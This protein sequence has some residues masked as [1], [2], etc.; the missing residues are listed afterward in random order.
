MS[1]HFVTIWILLVFPLLVIT[2]DIAADIAADL[3][4]VSVTIKSKS[5]EGSGVIIKRG[6][7][8]FVL[9]AG[10]VISDLRRLR[11]II[12]PR[13]GSTR[14]I[15]E[16]DEAKVIQNIY[17]NGRE[18][19][20]L[21]MLAVVICFSDAEYGE[22]IAL[23]RILKSNF[24]NASVS[25]YLDDM[26]PAVGTELYHVGSLHGHFGSNSVTTGIISQIGRIHKG[27]LYDQTNCTAFPGSSGGGVFIKENGECIGLLVRGSGGT[28]NLL[29]PIR[30]IQEWAKRMNVEFVLDPSVRVP[31]IE[32]MRKIPIQDLGERQWEHSLEVSEIEP[33]HQPI[34]DTNGF[35]GCNNRVK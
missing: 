13:T 8:N 10:H 32:D 2:D 22:D 5:S 24:I 1:K 28:F 11:Q 29:V 30:R 21:E 4:E 26:V 20:Q 15:I 25:F 34:I 35:D 27:K 18:V 17:E 6:D 14:N 7:Y 3:Q 16:F 23:L 33:H 12:D 9:T 19:G 31:S